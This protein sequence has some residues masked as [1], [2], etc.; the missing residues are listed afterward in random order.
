LARKE[1]KTNTSEKNTYYIVKVSMYG[2]TGAI[3][4]LAVSPFGYKEEKLSMH[5]GQ[6]IVLLCPWLMARLEGMRVLVL[7][8][9]C[10]F[11]VKLSR[12]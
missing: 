9:L 5:I 3:I 6:E 11:P 10:K 2:F 7:I 12:M 1:E 8:P 4:I